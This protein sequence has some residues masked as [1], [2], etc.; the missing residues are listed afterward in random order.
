MEFPDQDFVKTL[1]DLLWAYDMHMCL[2]WCIQMRCLEL[3]YL[4]KKSGLELADSAHKE[5]K[6]SALD[7]MIEV[8]NKSLTT[9]MYIV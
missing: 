8:E 7:L 3:C 2:M 5:T 6:Y 4:L 1:V 9:V